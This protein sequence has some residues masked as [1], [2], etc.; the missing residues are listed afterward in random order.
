MSATNQG[1]ET[2]NPKQSALRN[3]LNQGRQLKVEYVNEVNGWIRKHDI[4][5]M[6][7]NEDAMNETWISEAGLHH[8]GDAWDVLKKD[9]C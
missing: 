1:R 3:E 9:W 2:Q 4:D 7:Q 6:L 8:R 5:T